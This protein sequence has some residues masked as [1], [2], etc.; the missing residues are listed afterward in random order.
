MKKYPLTFTLA[1]VTAFFIGCKTAP[2]PS[3]PKSAS[4]NKVENSAALVLFDEV[5]QRSVLCTGLQEGRTPDG[6]LQVSANIR[7]REN[8]RVQVQVSCEFKD[9]EGIVVDGTPYKNL[10]LEENAQEAMKFISVNDKSQSYII[11][12]RKPQ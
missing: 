2:I 6:H 3:P 8:R 12:V 9:A 11:R 4:T 1:A 7:N 5:A 10:F